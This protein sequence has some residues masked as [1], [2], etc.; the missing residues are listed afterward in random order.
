M[1]Q[2][3]ALSSH[4]LTLCTSDEGRARGGSGGFFEAP[5]RLRGAFGSQDALRT[6]LQV[7]FDGA[8]EGVVYESDLFC[9]RDL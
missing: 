2:H 5:R 8:H 9:V 3:Y 4:A 1:F 6:S 7:G